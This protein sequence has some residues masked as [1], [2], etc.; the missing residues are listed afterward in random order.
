MER[1]EQHESP[2]L[3]IRQAESTG[4]EMRIR[5]EVA[6][7]SH[8]AL[9]EIKTAPVKAAQVVKSVI[10]DAVSSSS[11]QKLPDNKVDSAKPDIEVPESVLSDLKLS[12]SV[13]SRSDIGKCL[14]ELEHIDDIFHQAK[15]RG[16]EPE[17]APTVG[18]VLESLAEFN[19]LNINKPNDRA[20]LI[21]FLERQK[22]KAPVI[23]ISFPVEANGEVI[24]KILEWFRNEVHP[25]VVMYVGL[26]PELAAGCTLRTNSKHYDFSFRKRFEKSKQKLVAALQETE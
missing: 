11:D 14:R 22:V 26:Q 17:D 8:S 21:K 24:G 5:H 16:K 7:A 23:H 15:L 25:N 12:M 1:D 4:I 9:N 18:R 6:S 3:S 10:K 20:I 2:K 13:V 19:N